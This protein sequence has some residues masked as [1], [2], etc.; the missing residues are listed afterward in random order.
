LDYLYAGLQYHSQC[1]CGN[2]YGKYP[3]TDSICD[4]DCN[5]GEGICGGSWT[6]SVYFSSEEGAVAA[7]SSASASEDL[8][9]GCYKDVVSFF[10][11][12]L[13]SLKHFPVS[14]ACSTAVREALCLH[15]VRFISAS[16]FC[17]FKVALICSGAPSSQ[18]TF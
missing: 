16:D 12:A 9:I 18:R 4:T 8:Y 14:Q 2:E 15:V 17:I 5:E 13:P 7:Q 6:N 10:D 11:A 1:S 3:S